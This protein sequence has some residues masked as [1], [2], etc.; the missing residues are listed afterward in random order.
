MKKEL[1]QK[2]KAIEQTEFMAS[3]AINPVRLSGNDAWYF[4]PGREENTPPLKLIG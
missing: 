1:W 2:V 4:A 3:H